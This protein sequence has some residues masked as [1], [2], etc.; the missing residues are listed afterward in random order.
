MGYRSDVAIALTQKAAAWLKAKLN[1][2][3]DKEKRYLFDHADSHDALEV[4]GQELWRWSNV[5]WYKGYTEVDYVTDF[6][7]SL[8]E[9]DYLCIIV[10]E[11]TCDVEMSGN[12]WQNAFGLDV[13]TSI[14]VG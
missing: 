4:S 9:D 12:F 8:D 11:A 13:V 10:G 3:K 5:K 2:E 6:L 1:K 14:V 7:N